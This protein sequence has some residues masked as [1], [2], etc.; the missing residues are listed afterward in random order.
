MIKVLVGISGSGKTTL[1]KKICRENQ[2]HVRVNRDELRQMLFGYDEEEMAE[3]YK[4]KDLW[5]KEA[6][7]TKVSIGIIADILDK[8]YTVVADSTHLKTI[9]LDSYKDFDC[10][11]EF[12]PVEVSLEEAIERD[13]KRNRVVGR[14]IIEKQKKDFDKLKNSGIFAS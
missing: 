2:D 10:E 11:V 6:L 13:S 3:Y 8:G 4:L 14:E 7:V 12:I 9:Y 5:Y 1:A